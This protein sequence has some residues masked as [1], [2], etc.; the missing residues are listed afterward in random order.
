MTKF[1]ERK[2]VGI[3]MKK[4]KIILHMG[5]MKTGS[6]SIQETLGKNREELLKHNIYYPEIKPYN[7]L[8][9][10]IPIFL[11][12]PVNYFPLYKQGINTSIDANKKCE[13][14]QKMWVDEF[15]KCK[16]DNFIISAEQLSLPLFNKNAILRLK[17]ELEKYF[18]EII[19][20]VYIRHYET[21]IDSKLQQNIKRG[22]TNMGFEELANMLLNNPK[23]GISY[24]NNIKEWMNI[25]SKK[26][27]LVRPF[28]KKNFINGSLLDDF[29]YAVGLDFNNMKI[30]EIRTNES[31]GSNA[32]A[33]LERYNRK[34]PVLK[35]RKINNERGLAASGT[36]TSLYCSVNDE[37]IKFNINYTEEQAKKL[38]EEI[39]YINQFFEDGYEFQHVEAGDGKTEYPS[40]DDI[41]IEFFLELINNYNK[42]VERLLMRNENLRRKQNLMNK[43]N[44]DYNY[45]KMKEA[46]LIKAK[47]KSVMFKNIY[48]YLKYKIIG[49]EGFD[50]EYYIK[51][52]PY[53][54]DRAKDPLL[55]FL[56]RGVYNQSS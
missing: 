7:H 4:K 9:T 22:F 12:N 49:L 45:K 30:K 54:T 43:N 14:L 53:I 40:A 34:Y 32:V 46:Y 8:S 13:E 36:P 26:N 44:V 3:S 19:V 20:I 29:F 38:N 1:I 5:T 28:D 27:I 50:K 2:R 23:S 47:Q 39:N 42:H 11:D 21:L 56:I 48:K 16:C 33:F 25:F 37:K 24:S 18:E 52:Y 55:H 10:F 35:N 15:L 41:P 6:S 31:I 17:N 51:A